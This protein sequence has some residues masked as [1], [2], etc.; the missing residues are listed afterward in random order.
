MAHD[1]PSSEHPGRS[2]DSPLKIPFRG[3]LQIARRVWEQVGKDN[4][5]IVSAGVA[6]Y[7]FLS[8]FPA[9]VAFLSLYGLIISP[10]EAAEQVSRMEPLLPADSYELI[11]NFA[12]A[13]TRSTSPSLGWGVVL[14]IL[15]AVFSANKGTTALFTGLNI[16]YHQKES[17]HYIRR[18]LLTLG[19]TLGIVSA[20]SLL[21]A[22]VAVIPAVVNALPLPVRTET[23]LN[24][25]RWPLIV[26]LGFGLLAFFYKVAP[27][28][29]N[30]RWG[31]V[32]PGAIVA[33]LLWLLGS[34]GFGW[35]IE[36]FGNMSKTYGSLA[37]IVVLML[38]FFITAYAVLL[39]AEI[40]SECEYQTAHDTTIGPEKPM[41]SRGAYHA[42]HVVGGDSPP[43]AS[44]A[45]EDLDPDDQD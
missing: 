25:L 31:W 39:G 17:R 38:W 21:L 5:Q 2:A 6:F 23:F 9:I 3:W 26:I 16:A 32:T 18:T 28:R 13:L 42:D 12:E 11:A 36:S 41:G 14:S 33:M 15:F 27:H 35:Y 20:G 19:V 29:T 37:A 24:A 40:N 44:E 34:A 43:A 30:P 10:E 1:K 4:V 7:F 22:L 45:G 8:L